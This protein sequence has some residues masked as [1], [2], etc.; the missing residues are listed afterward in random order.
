MLSLDHC[1][2]NYKIFIKA[3]KEDPTKLKELH[4]VP[5]GWRTQIV[6]TAAL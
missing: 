4:I 6:N 3:N 5:M 2:E 1:V